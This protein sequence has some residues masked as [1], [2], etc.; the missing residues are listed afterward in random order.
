MTIL[1]IGKSA[2]KAIDCFLALQ[3]ANID[4]PMVKKISHPGSPDF[5]VLADV[6]PEDDAEMYESAKKI[7]DK[8]VRGA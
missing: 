1:W 2:A 5:E 7:V 3:E 8:V 4:G 6:H